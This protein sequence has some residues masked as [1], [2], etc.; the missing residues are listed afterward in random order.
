MSVEGH[1]PTAATPDTASDSR[2]LEL[3]RRIVRLES[4]QRNAMGDEITSRHFRR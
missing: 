3:V 1:D 2:W 4:V